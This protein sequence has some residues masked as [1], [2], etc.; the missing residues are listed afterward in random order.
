MPH[1]ERSAL[2]NHSAEQMFDLV[3][4]VASYPEYMQGCISARVVNED[5]EMLLGELT[6]GRAGVEFT[7]KTRN[8]LQ[9]P[10]RIDMEL[11]SGE[12]R[13]FEASWIFEALNDEASKVTLKMNFE[14]ANNMIAVAAGPL[15][16]S[17]AN[18]Q[19]DAIVNRAQDVYGNH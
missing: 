9:R 7:F 8:K 5:S 6:L 16:S 11:D 15:F 1:I 10:E 3:N 4:D 12:F 17:V 19:V 2:V 13:E 18:A 14:F